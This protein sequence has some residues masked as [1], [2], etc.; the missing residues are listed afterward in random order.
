[1]CIRDRR[2][3]DDVNGGWLDPA[4]VRKAREEEVGWLRRQEVYEKRTLKECLE[5]TG[6]KPIRLMWLDTNKGDNERP[7]YRSRIVVR[8]KRGQGEEGRKLPAALLFSAMPPLEA[9]K[10]L[11]GLMV[12]N[13]SSERGKPLGMRFFDI[14]R[15]HFYG[16]AERTV[17]VELPEEEQDGVHCA[18]LKKSMYGTQDASAIWQRDYTAVLKQ[19]GHEAGKANPA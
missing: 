7:N 17:Y 6:A 2:Y 10:M 3:W 1:M 15:A 16:L 13:R 14:S 9:V 4:M 19:D 11:G 8:E 5:V 12:Q 18:L